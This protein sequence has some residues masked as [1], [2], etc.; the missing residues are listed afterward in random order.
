MNTHDFFTR[1]STTIS[2]RLIIEQTLI[3]SPLIIVTVFFYVPPVLKRQL[4]LLSHPQRP[5]YQTPIPKITPLLAFI[6][7]HG[8]TIEPAREPPLQKNKND[9]RHKHRLQIGRPLCLM[10]GIFWLLLCQPTLQIT[11][12]CIPIWCKNSLVKSRNWTT[13]IVSGQHAVKSWIK[14][15]KSGN[16]YLFLFCVDAVANLCFL[17]TGG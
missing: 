7:R 1:L 8:R 17:P 12:H 10:K 5:L 11:Y 6:A 14:K 16:E 15:E 4:R 13:P 3:N 2:P 9:R